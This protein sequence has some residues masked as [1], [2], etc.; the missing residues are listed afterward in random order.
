M[1]QPTSP[2]LNWIKMAND[3]MRFTHFYSAQAVCSA[4][5]AGLLTGCYPNRIGITGAL[6]P[7]AK[8]GIADDELTMAEMLK[9]AGYATGIFGKWHLGHHIQFL[10]LQHGF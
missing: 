10:P 5:R 1:G 4:S 8:H 6:S 3:G 9:S 2:P 7:R